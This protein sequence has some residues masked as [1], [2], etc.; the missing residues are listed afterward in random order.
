MS[1]PR[2]DEIAPDVFRISVYA[3]QF[4]LQFNHFLV[5]DDEPLLYHTGMR[6]MFPALLSAVGQIIDPARLRHIAF[7]HFESDECGAL[8]DW[9]AVAPAAQPLAG[10]VG[11]AVNLADFSSRPARTLADGE[12]FETGRHR[13]RFLATPHLPHGWDAQTLF[14]ETTRTLFVGD[15]FHQ[16]GPRE[17]LTADD[18]V[19]RTREALRSYQAGPLADY[20]PYTRNTPILLERLAALAPRTLAIMHG[21]SYEGDGGAALRALDGVLHETFGAPAGFAPATP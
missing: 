15:L 16:V 14:D 7:G 9:L 8:N 10:T 5:R 19:A 6:G 21:S 11:A 12:R 18:V 4:D 3:P 13:F 2:I 20:V 1:E 17:P